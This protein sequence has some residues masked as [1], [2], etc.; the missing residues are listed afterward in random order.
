MPGIESM[1]RIIADFSAVFCITKQEL[2]TCIRVWRHASKIALCQHKGATL[3]QGAGQSV[4]MC[5]KPKNRLKRKGER[6]G[7]VQAEV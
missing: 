4:S 3:Q 2:K 7:I 1:L 5:M 6:P